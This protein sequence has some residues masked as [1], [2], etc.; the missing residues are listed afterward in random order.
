M[1][2]SS[3][4]DSSQ[5]AP[6]WIQPGATPPL[7][8]SASSTASP[9]TPDG[10]GSPLARTAQSTASHSAP[11]AAVCSTIRPARAVGM[12]AA[13]GFDMTVPDGF[14]GPAQYKFHPVI[15]KMT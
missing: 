12:A 15:N 8:S 4:S 13:N 6:S 10:T 3:M 2:N 7:H 5:F 1:K 9:I 11:S 14:N